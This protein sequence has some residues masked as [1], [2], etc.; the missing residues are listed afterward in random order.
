M[1]VCINKMSSLYDTQLLF[2]RQRGRKAHCFQKTHRLHEA[3]Q[4]LITQK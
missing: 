4:Y 2:L 1:L 3:K